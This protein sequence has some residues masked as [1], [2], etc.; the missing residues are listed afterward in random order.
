MSFFLEFEAEFLAQ[1]LR[2]SFFL[3]FEDEFLA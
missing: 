2:P 1:V 3:E